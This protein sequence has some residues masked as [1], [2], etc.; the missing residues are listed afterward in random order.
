MRLVPKLAFSLLAGVF[1][2]V[3]AF[4]AW[5]VRGEVQLFD[6][7]IRRDQ[8]IIGSTAAA[9]LSRT[10]TR[11][12]A[13][14]LAKRVDAARENL[15]VNFVSLGQHPLPNLK[16]RLALPRGK[17]LGPGVL[18]QFVERLDSPRSDYLITYV[19]APVVD[20]PHG[21]IELVESLAP[22][23]AY[24]SRGVWG[25]VLSSV[26][27][28]AVCGL[29][30]AS[31]GAKMVGQPVAELIGAARL[32]GAGEFDV[33]HDVRR[34]DEFGELAR[35]MR[36]MSTELKA[37]RERT[38]QETEA[39][40]RAL[41]QLRHAERLATLGQLASVLAHE[42]GTPLNVI[43]GHAKM[44]STGMLTGSAS[45]ES[46]SAIVTQ[47]DR[48]TQIVRRILDY[49]RR[50]PPRRARVDA[51]DVM[52]ES[53]ELLSSL[54]AQRKVRLRVDKTNA[55][56]TLFADPDQLQQA[57]TNLVMNAIH[58][59]NPDADVELSVGREARSDDSGVREFIS[60][61]VRDHG[62]GISEAH[63]QRV[64]EPFFTTKPP[65]E[66]TGLGLSVVRDIVQEHGGLV[67]L[68]SEEGK[69]STF[70]LLL[71]KGSD[72]GHSRPGG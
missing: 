6:Q 12:E 72:N 5:R 23:A 39:R 27:M 4:T 67:E 68:A 28:V 33:L 13:L 42:I 43:A 2:V 51:A 71:P 31:I 50:R 44:M 54:A 19:G 56:T 8:R 35:A 29:I 63:R 60:L 20:E 37:A 21:A 41:E 49:A 64:F 53:C 57:I 32:I 3:A 48:M 22:R 36:S 14:R 9:A 47:C 45:A 69:G 66:G 46:S 26:A 10:R 58:V 40:I 62:L 1:F 34:R 65:G 24:I 30:V 38:R 61:S 25:V 16:P 15:K 7:D 70:K 18:E 11:E 17:D 52:A 59:S 55:D